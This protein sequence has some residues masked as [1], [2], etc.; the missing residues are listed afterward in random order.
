MDETIEAGQMD[1]DAIANSQ[2]LRKDY[3]AAFRD[4]A[5]QVSRLKRLKNSAGDGFD[6]KKAEDQAKAA[7]LVYQDTRNRL[8]HDM[9]HRD[10]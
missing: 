8:T 6:V 7:E 9:N 2:S 3:R 1:P 4:W 10:K 5:L